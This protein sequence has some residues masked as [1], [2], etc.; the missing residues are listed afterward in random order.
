MKKKTVPA[1]LLLILLGLI[2]WRAYDAHGRFTV[3]EYH[4]F[5][6]DPAR[7]TDYTMTLDALRRDLDWLRDNGYTT[8]L[9]RE[10]ATGVLDDGSP[11]PEK[12]VLLTF[13]DGY[14]SNF[15]L[16][17]P[18]L[19]EY[20]AKATISLITSRIDAEK[21]SFLSWEQCREMAES[22]LVEFASHTHDFHIREEVLGIDRMEGETQEE[23]EARI[24]P[25]LETSIARIESETGQRATAFTY[26]LGNM[27]PWA[28]DF[29]RAHFSV[30]F[31]GIYGTAHYR[32]SF[33]RLPR[34]NVSDAHPA[35]EYAK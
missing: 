18:L 32:D 1:L 23:Y 2:I 21:S 29:L 34:C 15:T 20:G 24:F 9:P 17:F 3:L 13:D 35:S 8:V 14:A 25:D 26:P 27:D 16:A 22:G 30:T 11:L 6:E 5:T 33:Y 7:A 19:Q 4:D 31:S 12:A 10:L 28:E